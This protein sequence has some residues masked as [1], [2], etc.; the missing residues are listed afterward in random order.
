[1]QWCKE[2][3]KSKE[4]EINQHRIKEYHL[5][6]SLK[7]SEEMIDQFL[8]KEER[9]YRDGYLLEESRAKLRNL[10]DLVNNER[11]S[12]RMA[13]ANYHSQ[14]SER[15]QEINILKLRL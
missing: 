1:L 8:Q 7:R 6:A 13:D 15:N 5:S 14:L 12:R 10:E 9:F 11:D 2:Q 4:D 3:L